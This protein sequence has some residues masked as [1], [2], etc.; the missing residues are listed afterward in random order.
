MALEA[1]NEVLG[2]AEV[3]HAR[4]QSNVKAQLLELNHEQKGVL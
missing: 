2:Y 3:W 4:W 1:L